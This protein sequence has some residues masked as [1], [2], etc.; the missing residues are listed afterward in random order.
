MPDAG[1]RAEA[2]PGARGNRV[3]QALLRVALGATL[4]GI[5]V[6]YVDAAALAQQF[7][8]ISLPLLA[9]A[10]ASAIT[11]NMISAIRWS[12]IARALG[13]TAPRGRLIFMYGRGITMNTLLPG[14][15][16]SGD[17]LRSVELARLG[18]PFLRSALSVLVDR[19]SG[20]WTL[21][22]LSLVAVSVVATWQLADVQKIAGGPLAG[23]ILLLLG[24]ILL[25]LLPVPVGLLEHMG[26]LGRF[27]H[28]L[29]NARSELLR[30]RGALA[31]S[32]WFSVVVQALSAST[33]WICG[34]AVG[35]TLSYPE[36][37]AAAAP[38]FVMAAVPIGWAGFGTRELAA[39]VV[40]GAF[41]VPSNQATAAALLFGG[42]VIVQGVLAAPLFLLKR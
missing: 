8:R 26:P 24:A 28:K 19:F 33:L 13:L 31:R 25:P 9:L 39:V 6:W 34:R 42:T 17:V 1:T 10:L 3:L 14:A 12:L 37:L 41:G 15:T 36:M 16:L 22:V 40:L 7:A 18:N 32:V 23:Y 35:L 2:A 38:I 5:V 29:D 4:L 27:A 11:A 30:A 20:L 21:C